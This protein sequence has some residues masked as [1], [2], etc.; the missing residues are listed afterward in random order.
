MFQVALLPHEI[1]RSTFHRLSHTLYD[2]WT[3]RQCLECL[4][5][6]FI[7]YNHDFAITLTITS[8]PNAATAENKDWKNIVFGRNRGVI[9]SCPIL[10]FLFSD[11]GVWFGNI[12]G[13]RNYWRKMPMPE[14][15]PTETLFQ[16][17]EG[18]YFSVWIMNQGQYKKRSA[19]HLLQQK[20]LLLLD[21]SPYH[22]GTLVW[23]TLIW[24]NV[25]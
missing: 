3:E 2:L 7:F 19:K 4:L 25:L 16:I 8:S 10:A 18:G 14:L 22:R 11:W 21:S 20:K 12:C 5:T 24:N 13:K 15:L 1:L 6:A 17:G 9:Q 23:L